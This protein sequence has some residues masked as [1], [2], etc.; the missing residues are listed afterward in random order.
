M[1]C[2]NILRNILA[3]VKCRYSKGVMDKPLHTSWEKKQKKRLEQKL[4]KEL[5]RKLKEERSQKLTVSAT[6][7]HNNFMLSTRL[8]IS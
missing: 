3:I 5:E 6:N 2:Y 1:K 4:T 7:N 8:M